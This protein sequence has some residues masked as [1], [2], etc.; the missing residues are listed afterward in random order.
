MAAEPTENGGGGG[1]GALRTQMYGEKL[2]CKNDLVTF[3]N[4]SFTTVVVNGLLSDVH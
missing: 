1:G 3:T 2:H 4:F